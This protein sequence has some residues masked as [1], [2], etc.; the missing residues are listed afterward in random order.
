MK[1]SDRHTEA[2]C[3]MRRLSR[4]DLLESGVALSVSMALS[5]GK[6]S[7]ETPIS[8]LVGDGIA[9]DSAGLNAVLS[10]LPVIWDGGL[11]NFGGRTPA[12]RFR[13]KG[14]ADCPGGEPDDLRHP[15]LA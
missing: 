14:T 10:G 4:R 12:G 5:S 9:D 6:V 3:A 13:V 11:W 7:G 8:T 15:G 1:P 2:A